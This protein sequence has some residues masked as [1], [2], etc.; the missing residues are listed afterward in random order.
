MLKFYNNTSTQFSM[1]LW[2]QRF[3]AILIA[4][5]CVVI[6]MLYHTVEEEQVMHFGIAHKIFLKRESQTN[7]CSAAMVLP[8]GISSFKP[9]GSYF[10]L[11]FLSLWLEMCKRSII[12]F[13]EIHALSHGEHH[14]NRF[15]AARRPSRWHMLS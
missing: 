3:S 7:V 8:L 13:T 4:A 5:N 10:S 2:K 1:G 12:F 14:G 15:L 6:A 11:H 9:L